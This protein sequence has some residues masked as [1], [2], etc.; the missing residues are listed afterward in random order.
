MTL[1][2]PFQSADAARLTLGQSAAVTLDGTM[3]TLNATVESVSTADLVGSGGSL[4]RQVKL[5][6]HNP[7]CPV[8]G[9]ERHRPGGGHRLCRRGQAPGQLPPDHH[10]PDQRRGD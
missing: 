4:V 10:R 9:P 7:R 6:L 1:T 8:P 5:R 2:L 3:E